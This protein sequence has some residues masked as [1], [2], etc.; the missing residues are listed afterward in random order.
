MLWKYAPN[1]N[2]NTHA[3]VWFQKNCKAT[4][5]KSHLGMG[6]GYLCKKYLHKGQSYLQ[7]NCFVNYPKETNLT[8][9]KISQIKNLYIFSNAN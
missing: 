1:L 7:K 5:L 2:E 3:E 4:L 6:V 9:I 8:V